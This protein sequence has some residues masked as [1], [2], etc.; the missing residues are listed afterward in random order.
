M[1][2]GVLLQICIVCGD[3]ALNFLLRKV[4]GT[5]PTRTISLHP[6]RV[7]ACEMTQLLADQPAG[8]AINKIVPVYKER[9]QREF[10]MARYGFPKLI[11]ALEAIEDIVEVSI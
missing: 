9:F 10:V 7:F 6:V 11:R 5:G 2:L 1:Y 8:L 4:T 3:S